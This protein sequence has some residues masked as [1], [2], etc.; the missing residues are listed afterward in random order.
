MAGNQEL[1][2][3]FEML[4]EAVKGLAVNNAI[5]R[6]QG[7]VDELNN[8][9][10]LDQFEKIKQQQAIAK[11][12]GASIIGFGGSASAAQNA[13]MSLAPDVPDSRL[14]QL[15]ATGKGSIAEAQ[16]ALQE[17]ALQK[18]Q[19]KEDR[20]FERQKKLLQLQQQGAKTLQEMKA[21]GKPMK[22]LTR[23]ESDKLYTLADRQTSLE[24]LLNDFDERGG[25]IGPIAGRVSDLASVIPGSSAAGFSPD[26][27]AYRSQVMQDFNE[28]RRIV[29]GAAAS[30]PELKSLRPATIVE[31]DTPE[32]FKAKA[33]AILA[34]GKLVA[35]KRLDI[36]RR[37][38]KD[39]SGFEQEFDLGAPAAP[40]GAPN[41][42]P[43][44]G[45]GV[46]SFIKF[47]P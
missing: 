30:V 8:N 10:E 40:S 14:A 25:A 27:I 22:Q 6:A 28:Y 11:N 45:S 31:T 38:G 26:A 44:A 39:V 42:T 21:S 12:V 13:M 7:K 37:Q 47:N 18:E 43:P 15:E 29:T 33:K 34:A 32:N 2:A 23:P 35:K 9:A 5:K 41:N 36:A 19:D 20:A 16:K 1:L 24:Q 46:S 4:T 17:E 3:S